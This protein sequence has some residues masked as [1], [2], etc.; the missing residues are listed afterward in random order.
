MMYKSA[1]FLWIS[2]KI[3]PVNWTSNHLTDRLDLN[4]RPIPLKLYGSNSEGH[5]AAS[6]PYC[7][8]VEPVEPSEKWWSEW[9]TVGILWNSDFFNGKSFK[10]PWFQ[11]PPAKYL[12]THDL[13]IA[14]L[15]LQCAR[16]RLK[17]P[18]EVLGT[19]KSSNI[20]WWSMGQAMVLGS[21]IIQ[22][23]AP[24]WCERWLK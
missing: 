23:G 22:C 6:K 10:I 8:V 12:R 18:E 14:P 15:Q 13:F 19:P 1:D 21:H 9:V 7:L 17:P 4:P 24:Q 16:S 3:S 11:S 2:E 5:P 20:G